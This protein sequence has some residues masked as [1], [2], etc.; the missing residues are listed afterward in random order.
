M[1]AGSS[2]RPAPA[3]SATRKVTSRARSSSISTPTSPRRPDPAVIRSPSRRT[4]SARLEAVGIGDPDDIVVYDD[5]GGWIAA[6][7]WWMLDDLG[8]RRVGSSM[9]ACRPGSPPASRP[10]PPNRSAAARPPPP[11]RPVDQRHRSGGRRR[12]ARSDRPARCPRRA[13]LPRRGRA[14]RPGPRPHP[15]RVGT[16]RPTPTSGRIDGCSRGRSW[17]AVRRPRRHCRVPG[18]TSCGSGV[19]A[20]FTSLAMR[21][22]GCR[23]RSSTRAHTVT[24]AAPDCRQRSG[25]SRENHRPCSPPPTERTRGSGRRARARRSQSRTGAGRGPWRR[26]LNTGGRPTRR[27]SIGDP[28]PRQHPTRRGEGPLPAGLVASA[29]LRCR[30]VNGPPAGSSSRCA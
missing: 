27:T 11:A 21:V 14:D 29:I 9:A 10:R 12:R 19:T 2:A 23:T 8:H 6:R 26:G 30:L 13:A 5:V 7:L 3:G 22:A 1:C 20:C 16:R 28:R 18:V 15:D 25:P 17:P 4:L 24:G